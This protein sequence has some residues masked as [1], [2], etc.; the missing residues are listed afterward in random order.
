MCTEWVLIFPCF[1]ELNLDERKISVSVIA[2]LKLPFSHY[3]VG[4][5]PLTTC[6]LHHASASMPTSSRRLRPPLPTRPPYSVPTSPCL[7]P[8][9][10]FPR[11]RRQPNSHSRL[12]IDQIGVRRTVRYPALGTRRDAGPLCMPILVLLPA[13]SSLDCAVYVL[14][15]AGMAGGSSE[16][17]RAVLVVRERGVSSPLCICR[18]VGIFYIFSTASFLAI[19]VPMFIFFPLFIAPL[20]HD[21]KE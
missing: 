17:G 8:Q 10:P 16:R 6:A 2:R 15:D 4:F 9:P 7:P 12:H 1:T 11:L 20:R 14:R 3:T 19:F 13:R 5:C 18:W 21:Q